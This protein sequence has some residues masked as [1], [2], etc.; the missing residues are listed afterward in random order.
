MSL[1]HASNRAARLAFS[2]GI[3]GADVLDEAFDFIVAAMKRAAAERSY[4]V[5]STE[6]TRQGLVEQGDGKPSQR[7]IWER[8]E[9]DKTLRFQWRWYDQSHAYRTYPDMN[10]L[11][12]ELS[13]TGQ[14]LR[15]AEERYED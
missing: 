2:T 4:I 9:G 6:A 13:Q 8:T 11:S 1:T 7:N 12:V 3:E 15:T 5:A 10:V 14:V